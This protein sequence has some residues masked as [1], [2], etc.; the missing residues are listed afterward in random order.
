VQHSNS[1][2]NLA[3]RLHIIQCDQNMMTPQMRK[4][5]ISRRTRT[6]TLI[7]TKISNCRKEVSKNFKVGSA[8]VEMESNSDLQSF[9]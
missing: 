2:K 8:S 5:L 3:Y 7:G 9:L 1:F 4:V 6:I